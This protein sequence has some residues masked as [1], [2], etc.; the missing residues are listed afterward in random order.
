M[1]STETRKNVTKNEAASFD[2]LSAQLRTEG[3][4]VHHYHAMELVQGEEMITHFDPD[5]FNSRFWENVSPKGWD[6]LVADEWH[7]C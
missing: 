1:D 7:E 2:A 4:D 6:S 5:G 3:F